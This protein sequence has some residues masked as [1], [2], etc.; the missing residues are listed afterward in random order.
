M[1]L[2]R[3]DSSGLKNQEGFSLLEAIVAFAMLAT[4]LI[5]SIGFFGDGIRRVRLTLDRER[6]IERLQNALHL[7]STEI[8]PPEPDFEIVVSRKTILVDQA[9]GGGLNPVLVRVSIRR[10][11]KELQSLE[12][13]LLESSAQ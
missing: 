6:E 10:G 8:F 5:T 1:T 2:L 13:I 9:A 12:T 11:P 7:L 4:V 3:C